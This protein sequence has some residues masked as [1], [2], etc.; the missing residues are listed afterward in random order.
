M[1]QLPSIHLANLRYK[2][3]DKTSFFGEN[4][5]STSELEAICG[6]FIAF[7]LRASFIMS[8]VDHLPSRADLQG[9]KSAGG[10]TFLAKR[11]P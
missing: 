9:V 7:A 4:L 5:G 1:G 6:Q 2:I 8:R 3:I 10:M 11:E